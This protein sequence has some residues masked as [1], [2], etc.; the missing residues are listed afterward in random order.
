MDNHLI[1]SEELFKRLSSS[2][3]AGLSNQEVSK[4]LK[5]FGKNM[6]SPPPSR[7]FRKTVTYLFGGFGSILFVA[8]ILVFIAWR[9]LGQPP[10][11]ANLALA[12]VLILVW[13]IQALFSFW[14]GQHTTKSYGH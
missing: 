1:P 7:W 12:I 2:P 8:G 11:I 5:E 13:V 9:P 10:A 3:A 14:Q 4:R 6:P